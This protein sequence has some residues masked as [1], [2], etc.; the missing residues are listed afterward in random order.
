VAR[1]AT[2]AFTVLCRVAAYRL[3]VAGYD[4]MKQKQ[5]RQV[6]ARFSRPA[7]TAFVSTVN[8]TC[9]H[10]KFWINW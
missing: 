2:T 3:R 5:Q 6:R 10:F 4:S 8:Q 7:T 9:K 1:T